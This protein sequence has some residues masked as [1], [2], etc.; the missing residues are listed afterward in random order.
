[1]M[2][3][4]LPWLY[5]NRALRSFSTAFLT[6]VFPLYLAVSGYSAAKI[7]L[8]LSLSGIVSV[9]LLATVGVL[10]DSGRKRSLIGLGVL[11]V[12]G[13][14]AMAL[15]PAMWVVVLAS[16]LGG[17]GKGGGAGSGGSWGPFLPAEQPLLADSVTSANRTKVFG[18]ISFV[19]VITGAAGSLVAVVPAFLHNR[20]WSWIAGYHV[21]FIASAGLAVVMILSALPLRE[22]RR[23][24]PSSKAPP[25][26]APPISFRQLIGRLGLTN[27]LNGLAM[28]FMGPLLTYWF[29]RRYGAGT[30]ELGMF[31]AV[32]NLATA[33]P[34]LLASKVA[35]R[36]GAVNAVSVTRAL[37]VVSL[38][39][40]AFMPAFWE[41][42]LW[43]LVRMVFNSL[44][45]PTRQSYT[46]GVSDDRYRSRVAAFSTLPAQV[47]A[48]I[49]PVIGGVAMETMLDFPIFG[50]A[51]FM[52][53]NVVAYSMA[54]RHV[55]PP[56]ETDHAKHP[57]T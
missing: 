1:M 9:V 19:G 10:A 38:L 26:D 43:F 25:A 42:A 44:G 52:S 50:A 54:F 53:L 46:M 14:L 32:V 17:V 36:M 31:Y 39:A 27:S 55:L 57:A 18:Q 8:V 40:M 28:G 30:A 47:T 11:A 24:S 51:F 56:E 29:Y 37:S 33:V 23:P 48:M 4:N 21:L 6:V 35:K 12:L 3:R 13:G 15:S 34:Y 45:M 49:S 16:G 20:G 41:A 2:G 7:G 5:T 22:S